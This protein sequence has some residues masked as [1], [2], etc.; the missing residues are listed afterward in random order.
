MHA[1][2]TLS[3]SKKEHYVVKSKLIV[4]IKIRWHKSKKEHYV[5]KSK[6]LPHGLRFSP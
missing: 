1:G 2:E 5:V 3:Q 6:P 4:A